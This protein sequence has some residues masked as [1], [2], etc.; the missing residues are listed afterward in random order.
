MK[1]RGFT[2]VEVLVAVLILAFSVVSAFGAQSGA[3]ATRNYIEDIS[4]ALQLARCKMNEIELTVRDEGGFQELDVDEEGPCCEISDRTDFSCN[5][6]L[7]R[8]ELPEMTTGGDLEGLDMV[9]DAVGMAFGQKA[10]D[11]LEM[12]GGLG[13]FTSIFMPIL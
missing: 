3:V 8:V 13:S 2:L 7:E 5:W 4:V 12:M 9:N 6:K 11:R 1:S 10:A